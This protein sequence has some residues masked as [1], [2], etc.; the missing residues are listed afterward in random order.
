LL[1]PSFPAAARLYP[2]YD[3]FV[4][5]FWL[6]FGFVLMLHA[7][8]FLPWQ[9]SGSYFDKTEFTLAIDP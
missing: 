8:I 1:H 9:Y 2:V 3:A 6:F 4:T 5:S 7:L